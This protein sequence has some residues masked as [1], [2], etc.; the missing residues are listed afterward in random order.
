MGFF[1]NSPP[2][3]PKYLKVF[4]QQYHEQILFGQL[5]FLDFFLERQ[6]NHLQEFLLQKRRYLTEKP[7]KSV[8]SAD[9]LT[10]ELEE[11][12]DTEQEVIHVRMK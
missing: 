4:P 9:T 5:F 7:K 2:F 1:W 11:G 8:A 12:Q 3:G 6:D 10:D